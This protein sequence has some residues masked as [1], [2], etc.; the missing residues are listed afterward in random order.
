M[1][2]TFLTDG[3]KSGNFFHFGMLID[4]NPISIGEGYATGYS[5][6]KGHSNNQAV[7]VAFDCHNLSKVIEKLRDVYPNSPITICGDDDAESDGNPGRSCAEE[8]ARKHQCK[9]MF[10]CFSSDFKL[11]NG[12]QPTDFNDLHFYL[13]LEE[14]QKQLNFKKPYL[15]ALNI[16]DLLSRDFPPRKLILDPWLAEKGLTMIYA[17]RGLGKTFLSLSAAYAIACGEPILKWKAHEPRKVL[18]IDGEMPAITMQ[19]RLAAITKAS[20]KTPP[21]PS[22]FR[23]VSHEFQ[24]EGIHD[25]GSPQGQQDINDLMKEADLVILDNLS[26]LVRSGRMKTRLIAGYKFKNGCYSCGLG[27]AVL[28]IHHA[29]KNGLQRGT[30]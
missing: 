8:A 25:V 6:F 29:G 26:T 20:A 14:L 27:K 15:H 11:P 7:V 28:L 10:P 18:Y 9:V 21:N 3:E 4:G 12:K 24:S 5:V 17:P 22:Y 13:G 1:Y 23:I 30:Q 19:E 2:K 16:S